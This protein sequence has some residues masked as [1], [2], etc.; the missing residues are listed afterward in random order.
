MSELRDKRIKFTALLC[1][2]IE[3]GNEEDG[4]EIALG[5]DYDEGDPDERLRHMPG[6]LHYLGLANDLCLYINGVYQTTTEAYKPLGECWKS[7]GP[8]CRWGGE[9]KKPDGNHFSL[10]YRGKS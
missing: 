2:L 5:R 6:S 7:L 9:F 4:W 1:E 10:T 8:D 3:W